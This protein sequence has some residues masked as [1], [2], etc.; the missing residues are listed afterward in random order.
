MT[1]IMKIDE[2]DTSFMEKPN[3]LKP[4]DSTELKQIIRNRLKKDGPEC[5]LND[6]D[7]SRVT[8]MD[9]LFWGEKEFN[10]DISEWDV[11]NVTSMNNMFRFA[12]RFNCDISKWDVSKVEGMEAMFYDAKAFDQDL[13]KWDVS[14]VH[15]KRLV[16][17]KCTNMEKH[18]EKQP[19][20]KE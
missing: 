12:E 6:I 20:F 8:Y 1:H 16:F 13:S 10:G 5:N 4:K 17:T 2:W 3:P 18:P 15:R 9:D 11:S 7:V 19:K 14:K